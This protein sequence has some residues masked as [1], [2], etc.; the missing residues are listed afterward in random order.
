MYIS[1]AILFFSIASCLFSIFSQLIVSWTWD[2]LVS[3]VRSW[4]GSLS[5]TNTHV[6]S[7]SVRLRRGATDRSAF[8]NTTDSVLIAYINQVRINIFASFWAFIFPETGTT[9][10]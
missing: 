7:D 6:G 5:N 9:F 10:S 2:L 8:L 1:R 3:W 4:L